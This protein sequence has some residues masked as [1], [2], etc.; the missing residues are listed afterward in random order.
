MC[1][2]GIL[3]SVTDEC[4]NNGLYFFKVSGSVF[5]DV[6]E[7]RSKLNVSDFAKVSCTVTLTVNLNK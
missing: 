6:I 1:I 4:V 2:S 5:E 3:L 7:S